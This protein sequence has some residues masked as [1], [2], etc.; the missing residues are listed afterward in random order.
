MSVRFLIW[1]YWS[2][3]PEDIQGGPY[4][5]G[6]TLFKHTQSK[7]LKSLEQGRHCCCLVVQSCPTLVTP[8]TEACQAPLSMGFPKQECWSRLPFP[9]Q[10]DLPH[11]GMESTSPD[12][13]RGFFTTEPPG[14]PSGQA[15]FLSIF[16][17]LVPTLPAS[18]CLCLPTL[19]F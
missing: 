18:C 3:S 13:A 8:W 5:P 16:L 6:E 7:H 9:S 1:G 11:S 10:G 2:Q 19:R 4:S 14:K 15:L 17:P 12:N